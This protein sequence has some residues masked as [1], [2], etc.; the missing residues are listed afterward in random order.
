LQKLTGLTAGISVFNAP[1]IRGGAF[2][3]VLFFT[4]RSVYRLSLFLVKH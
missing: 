2:T 3:P 1:G 4:A